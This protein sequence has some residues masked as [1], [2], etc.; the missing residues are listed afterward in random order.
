MKKIVGQK[1]YSLGDGSVGS[2]IKI[3]NNIDM[4]MTDFLRTEK[5]ELN[6]LGKLGKIALVLA[7]ILIFV[8]ISQK[9]IEKIFSTRI[10]AI[11]NVDGKKVETISGIVKNIVRVFIYFVGLTII[12][13]IFHINMTGILTA[14]GIGGLAIG[15]GAQSLVKDVITG[16]FILFEGQ[17]SVGEH[18][19]IQGY[20]GIVEELGLRLTK[21]RDFNG[22]LHFIPNGQISTVTN[23]NRGTIKSIINFNIDSSQDIDLALRV[24]EKM[25]SSLK[26]DPRFILGPNILGVNR[27]GRD[28]VEI[29]IQIG[30]RPLQQFENERVLKKYIK[31]TMEKE[32]IDIAYSKMIIVENKDN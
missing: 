29:A 5:G 16:A 31:E 28:G 18:V 13:D 11:P 15:F 22:E 25:S 24:L 17:Y 3:K 32:N 7:L 9:L 27:F 19:E 10:K 26:S 2:F 4:I 14:A 23:K 30:S 1:R 6:F 8:K 20:E 21:I 12:L